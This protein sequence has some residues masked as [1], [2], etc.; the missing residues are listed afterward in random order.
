LSIKCFTAS[1]ADAYKKGLMSLS[2]KEK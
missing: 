1:I 2:V